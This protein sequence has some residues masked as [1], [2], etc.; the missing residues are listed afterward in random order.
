MVPFV[1]IHCHVLAGLDDGPA[2]LDESV[3]MCRLAWEQGTRIIVAT[4]H[5]SES[6]PEVTPKAIRAAC[7]LLSER[8]RDAGLQ[9]VLHPGAEITIFPDILDAW[10]NGQLL[11]LA[12]RREYLLIEPPLGSYF[13][14]RGLVKRLVALG[15]KPILAHAE[16]YPELLH[17]Q[18]AAQELANLGCLLQVTADAVAHPT[19]REDGRALKR[20]VRDGL[21]H[22]VASDGHSPTYRPP[23]MADAHRQLSAWDGPDTADRLCG[24]NGMR[25]VEGLPFA[26]APPKKPRQRWFS[27]R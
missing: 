3:E 24:I 10:I 16:R 15:V 1:D 12:G 21:V 9:M 26:A 18:P 11:G 22:L 13:D 6:W 25:V 5:L 17:H 7:Q 8:L 27:L 14:L 2:A 19:T 4:A 23:L 20:W